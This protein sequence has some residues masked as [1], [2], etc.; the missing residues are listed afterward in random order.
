LDSPILIRPSN[1]PKKQRGIAPETRECADSGRSGVAYLRYGFVQSALNQNTHAKEGV[2]KMAATSW[3]NSLWQRD[4]PMDPDTL[5]KILQQSD[6]E[7]ETVDLHGANLAK[8]NLSWANLTK[9]DLS[10]ADL[11]GADMS[12]VSLDE[13][14]LSN[15]KMRGAFLAGA[16]LSGATLNDANLDRAT[17]YEADLIEAKLEGAKLTMVDLRMANLLP[18]AR[19]IEHYSAA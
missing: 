8:A 10:G 5:R 3:W 14:N 12:A 19:F 15:A 18:G 6:R 17:L 1:G 9:A 2:S 16:N 7:G 4:R 13:A 11:T